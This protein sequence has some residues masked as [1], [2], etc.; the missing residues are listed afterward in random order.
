MHCV[1]C[2]I[3]IEDDSDDELCE[4]C[5]EVLNEQAAFIFGYDDEDDL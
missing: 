2:G 4:D 1:S 5:Q 3:V